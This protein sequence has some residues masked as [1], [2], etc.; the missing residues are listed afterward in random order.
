MNTDDIKML[1]RMNSG[2]ILVFFGQMCVCKSLKIHL[3]AVRA[4]YTSLDHDQ[5]FRQ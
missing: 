4:C 1:S 3:K 2:A 5:L